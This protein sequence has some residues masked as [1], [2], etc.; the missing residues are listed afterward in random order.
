[1][2]TVAQ[3]GQDLGVGFVSEKVNLKVMADEYADTGNTLMVAELTALTLTR[4]TVT[5]SGNGRYTTVRRG[6]RRKAPARVKIN[7]ASSHCVALLRLK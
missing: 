2:D 4:V 7:T 6:Y 1:M 5:L 3:G